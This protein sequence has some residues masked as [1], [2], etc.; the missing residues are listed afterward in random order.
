MGRVLNE[1]KSNFN[2]AKV[3]TSSICNNFIRFFFRHFC[4]ILAA[5]CLPKW[6]YSAIPAA[7]SSSRFLLLKLVK[8]RTQIESFNLFSLLVLLL[9]IWICWCQKLWRKM[10]QSWCRLKW[11]EFPCCDTSW[12]LGNWKKRF[13]DSLGNVKWMKPPNEVSFCVKDH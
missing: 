9:C 4:S 7:I 3:F 11:C 10:R 1:E 12:W 6:F 5:Y 8:Y 13:P 2:F